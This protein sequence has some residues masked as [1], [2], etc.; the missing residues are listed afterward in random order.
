MNKYKKM[1][2]KYS[3]LT[4]GK[5]H[6]ASFIEAK[7]TLAELVKRAIDKKVKLYIENEDNPDII[8]I[9]YC[10]CPSCNYTFGGYEVER[11]IGYCPECGQSLNWTEYD[12]RKIDE[13]MEDEKMEF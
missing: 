11:Q 13:E 8:Q 4:W 9:I 3:S 2:D 6:D 10:K 12:E 7:T 1:F 5:T